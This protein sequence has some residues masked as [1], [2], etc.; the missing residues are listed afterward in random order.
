[1]GTQQGTQTR[2]APL[3]FA[4]C[5]ETD[6][7]SGTTTTFLLPA[8]RVAA[9]DGVVKRVVVGGGGRPSP[10]FLRT[11][12]AERAFSRRHFGRFH[13]RGKRDDWLWDKGWRRRRNDDEKD[14]DDVF[15]ASRGR[16]GVLFRRFGRKNQRRRIASVGGRGAL[17]TSSSTKSSARERRRG[18]WRCRR[19]TTRDDTK[20]IDTPRRRRSERLWGGHRR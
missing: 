14:D 8:S 9:F 15:D 18:L 1:M 3:F 13:A 17:A 12:V 7:S 2:R 16:L 11:V 19:W 6:S 10:S 20:G 4:L 5:L